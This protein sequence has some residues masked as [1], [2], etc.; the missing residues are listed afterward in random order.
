M[1]V[2]KGAFDKI[3]EKMGLYPT[4]HVKDCAYLRTS[5][6]GTEVYSLKLQFGKAE[7]WTTGVL[8]G[9]EPTESI[10]MPAISFNS[11]EY[12]IFNGDL[13]RKGWATHR[14][15]KTSS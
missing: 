14:L 5:F 9:Y 10:D 1:S 8:T 7:I 4:V 2:V 13:S 3:L 6:G 11:T 15:D 12:R